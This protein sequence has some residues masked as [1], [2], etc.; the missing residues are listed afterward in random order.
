V[1]YVRHLKRFIPLSE[2]Q[3]YKELSDMALIKRGR[4]SV[5]PVKQEEWEFIQR[6]ED[7]EEEQQ[8]KKKKIKS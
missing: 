3:S 1:D 6:L 2:L 8:P 7:Q 4:L 5:Q